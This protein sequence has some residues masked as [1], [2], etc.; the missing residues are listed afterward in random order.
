VLLWT[1]GS[2]VW[3]KTFADLVVMLRTDLPPPALSQWQLQRD[4]AGMPRGP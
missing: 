2:Y 3:F 1:W 4:R